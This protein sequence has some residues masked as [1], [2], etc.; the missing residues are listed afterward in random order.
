VMIN[1][2]SYNQKLIRFAALVYLIEFT[3]IGTSPTVSQPHLCGC[4]AG[5]I[6]Q[7][8]VFIPFLFETNPHKLSH[9]CVSIICNPVYLIDF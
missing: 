4:V 3:C 5:V 1:K 8:K 9:A 2:R 7:I 6:V